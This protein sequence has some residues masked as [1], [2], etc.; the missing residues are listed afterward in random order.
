MVLK[1]ACYLFT[2][3]V[4]KTASR[5][6]MTAALPL[7]PVILHVSVVGHP[8]QPTLRR[9]VLFVAVGFVIVTLGR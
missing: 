7:S 9:E 6:S 5:L 2:G 3:G 1:A 4:T 8:L